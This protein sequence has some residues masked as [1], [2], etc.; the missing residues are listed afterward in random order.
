MPIIAG[1]KYIKNISKPI[2]IKFPKYKKNTNSF[3]TEEIIE[4][5]KQSEREIENGELVP[6]EVVFKEMRQKYGY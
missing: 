1:K 6:A 3:F 4:K 2:A 5:L